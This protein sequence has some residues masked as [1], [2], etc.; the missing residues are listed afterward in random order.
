MK[1]C[2]AAFAVIVKMSA[3][4]LVSIQLLLQ[5]IETVLL[6]HA[7]QRTEAILTVCLDFPDFHR[8][9]EVW[10][11]AAKMRVWLQAKRKR[12]QLKIPD[13]QQCQ[14]W[15]DQIYDKILDKAD[16]LVKIETP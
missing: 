13:E 3:G 9:L 12:A 7:A 10:E 11:S 6:E 4:L 14:S 15:L 1:L 2:R 5:Q 8:L 16:F